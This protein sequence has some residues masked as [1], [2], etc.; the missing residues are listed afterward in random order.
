MLRTTEH[1][2]AR[3]APPVSMRAAAARGL[4]AGLGALLAL[5]G[6]LYWTQAP[7]DTLTTVPLVAGVIVT[8]VVLL[9]SAIPSEKIA[10]ALLTARRIQQVQATV[11]AAEFR[12]RKAYEAVVAQEAR[13]A[14][15]ERALTELRNENKVLRSEKKIVT[16]RTQNPRWTPRSKVDPDTR[17]RA[18]TILQHWYATLRTDARGNVRGE[19]WS[20]PKATAAGWTKT[21]HEDATQL[22]ED[23]ELTGQNGL[24][25]FVLPDVRDLASAVHRLD[26][27]CREAEQEP[28]M[29]RPYVEPNEG[30]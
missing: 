2:A 12:K 14:E 20:R 8:G 16:E 3:P 30:Y 29:P 27:Y 19:W 26:A 9:V 11:N 24:L 17:K 5:G 15:L 7:L 6:G 28:V 13:L 4:A 1:A 23:A 22:L 25:P 18:E 10:P 21:Q